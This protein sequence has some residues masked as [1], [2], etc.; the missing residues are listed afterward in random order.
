MGRRNTNQD[1]YNQYYGQNGQYNNQY[2]NQ[3]RYNNQY[4]NNG[5]QNKNGQSKQGGKFFNNQYFVPDNHVEE[6]KKEKNTKNGKLD[7]IGMDKL[8][9]IM[10]VLFVILSIMLVITIKVLTSNDSSEEEKDT[11]VEYQDTRRVGNDV[12]GYISIPSEWIKLEDSHSVDSVLQY[13]DVENVY[14]VSMDVF[15]KGSKSL[16]YYA[17][18]ILNQTV[19]NGAKNTKVSDNKLDNYDAKVLSG[20]YEEDGKWFVIWC[21]ITGDNKVHWIGVEAP[22]QESEY[23]N[24]PTTFSLKK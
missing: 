20:Y 22:D 6:P 14:V 4:Y 9:I 13:T 23:Y 7:N 21:F 3:G 8:K 10:I 12:Y 5:R 15:D 16:E 24:I 17:D 18:N 1:N 2:N 11:K 19:T